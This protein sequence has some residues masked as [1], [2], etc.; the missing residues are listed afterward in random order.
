M[1]NNNEELT[2]LIKE[3]IRTGS[4]DEWW[5][6]KECHDEDK[7]SLLHHIICLANNRA[8]RDAYLILGVYG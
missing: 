6:F 1:I 7:A 4:E 8:Y 3:L 5:D 2:E